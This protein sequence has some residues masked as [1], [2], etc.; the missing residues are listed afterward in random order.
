[1]ASPTKCESR[2]SEADISPRRHHGLASD[3]VV[4]VCTENDI[5]PH[6]SAQEISSGDRHG[7]CGLAFEAVPVRAVLLLERRLERLQGHTRL[8]WVIEEPRN[9]RADE[10]CKERAEDVHPEVLAGA[11]VPK[12]WL[13]ND[14]AEGARRVDAGAGV[15]A[16]DDDAGEDTAS[17]RNRARDG[18]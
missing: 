16:M 13:E 18:S 15:G 2:Y 6:P 1:M 7:A 12:A 8:A 9:D 14:R 3:R 17:A 11:G 4:H 10:G 5:E